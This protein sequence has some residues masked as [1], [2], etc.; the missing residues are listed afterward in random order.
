[1]LNSYKCHQL[2]FIFFYCIL[3]M[4]IFFVCILYTQCIFKCMNYFMGIV[5]IYLSKVNIYQCLL[6][7]M[8]KIFG[9][10][11]T[12]EESQNVFC[13]CLNLMLKYH[14]MICSELKLFLSCDCKVQ[15]MVTYL[16]SCSKKIL[17]FYPFTLFSMNFQFSSLQFALANK[18]SIN[19]Y[20]INKL[21]TNWY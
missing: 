2:Y 20:R 1:M 9:E 6:L 3:L 15:F 14:I 7:I 4:F 17:H 13:D 12:R 16:K 8:P 21:S 5:A 10:L 18:F 11:F 19:L